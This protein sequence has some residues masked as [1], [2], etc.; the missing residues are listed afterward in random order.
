MC[1]PVKTVDSLTCT[2]YLLFKPNLGTNITHQT[3]VPR[4]KGSVK[5]TFLFHQ[6][7]D[8]PRW[9]SGLRRSRVHSLM[10]ARRS[11]RPEKL[12]SNP[13]QGSKGIN[14]SGWHGLDMS[15]TATKRC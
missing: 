13:G 2:K 6:K 4:Y 7:R 5:V 11:L 10:I 8:Q 12:G 1:N 3:H 15:I 9:L 14:F